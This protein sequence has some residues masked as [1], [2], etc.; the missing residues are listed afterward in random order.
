VKIIYLITGLRLGGAENQLSLLAV[1]MKKLGHT[2]MVVSMES[3][4][5][6][7][8]RIKKSGIEVRGLEIKGV[9][10]LLPG[11]IRFKKIVK[12]FGPQLIHAHMIHA[13]LFANAFKFFNKKYKLIITAHNIREGNAVAMSGYKLTRNIP[14]W[15]TNVSKEAYDHFVEEGYFVADKSSHVPNAIDTKLFDPDVVRDNGLRGD[16]KLPESTFVFLSAGRLH[17]QKNY[18]MLLKAFKSVAEKNQ[19]TVLVIAGEGIL[20]DEL[21]RLCENLDIEKKALFVGRRDDIPQLMQ[22]C[23]CFVLSSNFEGFGLVVAEA[24][25]MKKPVIATDC[26]GVKEVSGGYGTL[27]AVNDVT[28]LANAMINAVERP[29]NTEVLNSARTYINNQYSIN[30]VLDE[31]NKLYQLV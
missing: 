13:N 25:S 26:G 27:I 18:P 12:A 7:G 10:D 28:G 31:W 6:V 23:D 2:V 5:I 21:K 8:E 14:D 20:K 24:M 4:G 11:F 3:G 17:E 29:L 19:N 9:K 22:L 1:N 16:L 30:K 15:A